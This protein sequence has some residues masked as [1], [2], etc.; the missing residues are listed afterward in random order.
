MIQ[1]QW[2]K[3]RKT[4]KA[5]QIIKDE[6][7]RLKLKIRKIKILRIAVDQQVFKLN[8][9]ESKLIQSFIFFG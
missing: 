8:N 2:L 1:H 7:M 5:I 3:I 4:Q 6:R 9:V